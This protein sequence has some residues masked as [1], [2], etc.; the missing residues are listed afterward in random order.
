ME[1]WTFLLSLSIIWYCFYDI[2]VYNFRKCKNLKHITLLS[3]NI[4]FYNVYW[5]ELIKADI[6]IF[7]SGEKA[8]LYLNL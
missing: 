8:P 2:D 3:Y 5:T 4:K 6:N 7:V 1:I